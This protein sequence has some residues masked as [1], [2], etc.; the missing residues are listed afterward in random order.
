MV[1]PVKSLTNHGYSNHIYRSGNS[2]C[3]VCKQVQD[4]KLLEKDNKLLK[5]QRDRMPEPVA[6]DEVDLHQLDKESAMEAIRF[7]GFV[8]EA[9]EHWITFMSQGEHYAIDAERFPVMVMMKH[10]NLDH[11]EWDMDLMP[12]ISASGIG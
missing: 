10:Y 3:L 6:V 9:N 4:Y 8:P 11:N 2:S 5:E 12:M 7:N 1:K